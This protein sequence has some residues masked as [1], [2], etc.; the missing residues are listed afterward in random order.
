MERITMKMPLFL[1]CLLSLIVACRSV[2][3]SQLDELAGA[4]AVTPTPTPFPVEPPKEVAAWLQGNAVPFDTAVPGSGCADLQPLLAM[5]GD[6]R[7][8]ALGEATHGT[9]EFS[10]MKHRIV[11][12]LVEEKGFNLFLIEENWGET[13]A[14]NRYVQTG[15]GDA[16]RALRAFQA[17]WQTEELFDLIYWIRAHNENSGA[18]PTVS[19]HGYDVTRV[20]QALANLVDYVTEV[21][22]DG[23]PFVEEELRCFRQ[24]Y[25]PHRPERGPLR[26]T[27][28][29][30]QRCREGVQNVHD[31]LL[32]RQ[33]VHEDASAS[34]EYA[35]AVYSARLLVQ[36]EQ[37]RSADPMDAETRNLRELFMADNVA[38]LLEQAEPGA[39]V[40]IW[41]HNGHVQT[42]P[43]PVQF[44]VEGGATE[45]FSV[46]TPMGVHLR[47]RYGGEMVVVGFTFQRGVFNA[48]GIDT[49]TGRATPFGP[50]QVLPPVPGS[51]ESYLGLTGLPRYVLDLRPALAEESVAEWFQESRWI[52]GIGW[53]YNR[54]NVAVTTQPMILPKAFDILVY[55]EE[56]TPTRLR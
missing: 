50:Q 19:F 7:L 52:R 10:T 23:L 2:E 53:A 30:Y 43:V 18:R 13:L 15:A 39:K 37:F 6:A 21:D 49:A 40:I 35:Q 5:I 28:A 27:E 31:W 51:H 34:M 29:Q 11:E 12:C 3:P 54:N 20:Q 56:S 46:F 9:R 24:N 32:S 41:A 45:V 47:E 4:T 33:L 38:S 16:G 14:V 25:I 36:N 17:I 42:W 55:F 8:V 1:L 26:L 44:Y 22:P 48:S